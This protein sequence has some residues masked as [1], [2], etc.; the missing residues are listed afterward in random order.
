MNINFKKKLNGIKEERFNIN[1]NGNNNIF[2]LF[3]NSVSISGIENKENEYIKNDDI[4]ITNNYNNTLNSNI[5][6]ED[7]SIHQ[8][9]R[10]INNN[11]IKK[12]LT[13]EDLDNTP[14]PIFSC[15]YCSNDYISY[16]HLLDENLSSKYYIQTSIY[17]IKIL[18]ELIKYHSLIDQG[19]KN[20]SLINIIIKNIEYLKKYYTKEESIAYY[21]SNKFQYICTSNNLKIKNYFYQKLEIF[22]IRK[23][24]KDLTNKKI[25]NKYINKNISY[26]KLSFHNNNSGSIVNDNFYNA[27]NIK[28]TNNTFG[29]GTCQGTGSYSSMNNLISFSLYNNENN[30]NNNNILYLNNLNMMENIMEKIE[31]NEESENDEEGG[32]EFLN[33]FGNESQFQKQIN[34]NKTIFE[35]KFYDIWNPEITIIN[36]SE[37]GE[38]EGKTINNSIFKDKNY[39][40]NFKD[41][42]EK[43]CEKKTLDT[44][45][46]TIFSD[47]RI[48]E[49]KNLVN[50]SQTSCLKNKKIDNDNII[51]NEN[52]R[53]LKINIRKNDPS[54][55]ENINFENKINILNKNKDINLSNEYLKKYLFKFRSFYLN[56]YRENMNKNVLNIFI[57]KNYANLDILQSLNQTKEKNKENNNENNKINN[58][59][60][61]NDNKKIVNEKIKNMTINI[62]NHETKN[63]L[64]LLK[65][66][67]TT[68]HSSKINSRKIN[69]NPRSPQI[70]KKP[71]SS[72]INKDNENSILI[73]PKINTR[74]STSRVRKSINKPKLIYDI[75]E[76]NI[77]IHNNQN[78]M[79]KRKKIINNKNLIKSNSSLIFSNINERNSFS[80][81]TN[82]KMNLSKIRNKNNVNEKLKEL[83]KKIYKQ[84]N[85]YKINA[86]DFNKKIKEI[87]YKQKMNINVQVP[88]INKRSISVSRPLLQ[89]RNLIKLKL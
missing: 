4:N 20:S 27:R 21:K 87:K 65:F 47:K 50:Y 40:K 7:Q 85:N 73:K 15:I 44:N 23:K 10:E 39:L 24:N 9:N 71:F 86:Q 78:N 54:K 29:T 77:Q 46:K 43:I 34:T 37:N 84:N 42:N 63:L 33:I 62:G 59:N 6:S 82:F 32:E 31:K 36:E 66:P 70:T 3:E 14:L 76:N 19:N 49:N 25:N 88:L 48:N 5:I 16:K 81:S 58:Y 67:R 72:Y 56:K 17:D 79:N 13:K 75:Y 26:N 61:N 1:K 45:A 41:I 28:N 52:K 2:N 35:D 64:F 57:K 30:N 53:L 68:S 18:D 83:M 74:N 38:N 11:K 22:I 80:S 69:I 51:K 60:V 89:K 55:E 12:K 8:L